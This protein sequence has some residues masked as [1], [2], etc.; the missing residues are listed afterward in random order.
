MFLL[1]VERIE[2]Q[3]KEVEGKYHIADEESKEANQSYENIK[4][5]YEKL[6]QDMASM[7]DKIASIRDEMSASTVTKGKLEG[8][9]NVLNEQI[10]TAEMTDEH[11]KSRLDSIDREKQERI[12]SRRYIRSGKAGT[13]HRACGG[14]DGKRDGGRAAADHSGGD[15]ALHRGH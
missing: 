13:R 11:L 6:E 4:S 9:I 15:R 12:E 3:L 5:E 2:A 10:H 14:G 8:Q 7:D 1:E